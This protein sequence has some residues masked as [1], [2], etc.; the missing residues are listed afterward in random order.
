MSKSGKEAQTRSIPL[1][2]SLWICGSMSLTTADVEH[3]M[4]LARMQLAP[5]EVERM[6]EQLSSILDYVQSLQEVD[7]TGVPTTA[8]VTG[9]A[10][11]MRPDEVQPS[12]TIEEVV[13]N[14]AD[15]REGMFRV[16]AVFDEN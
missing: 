10:T 16:H 12:L 11:V 7:V 15:H 2:G 6:R 4:R 5:D 8:Q 9:L 14:A 3:V 13:R 1:L